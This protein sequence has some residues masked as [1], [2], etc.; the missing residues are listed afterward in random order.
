MDFD[1]FSFA[2][3]LLAGLVVAWAVRT[4]WKAAAESY[5]RAAA[6]SHET[7]GR[8]ADHWRAEQQARGELET[9]LH[10]AARERLTWEIERERW[11]GLGALIKGGA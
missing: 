10:T 7:L 6:M 1:V 3:G 9:R 5:K 11:L 2:A 4:E 8:A